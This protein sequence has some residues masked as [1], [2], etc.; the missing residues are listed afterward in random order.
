MVTQT[1]SG[2][3]V[4]VETSYQTGHSQPIN[5]HFVF[6]YK[7]MIE[8]ISDAYVQLI[9]RHW[10]IREADGQVREVKGEGVVGIQP[11]LRPGETYEYVSGCD[12]YTDM[13]SMEGRYYFENLLTKETFAVQ[14]PRFQM[15]YPYKA[16]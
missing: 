1:S 4:S 7:I 3:K 6:A 5:S 16:N 9:S 14:I 12:F 2:I 15:I 8:N 13:G 11:R 10:I